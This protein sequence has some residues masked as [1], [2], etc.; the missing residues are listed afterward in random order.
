M[1]S[2]SRK[3]IHGIWKEFFHDPSLWLDLRDNKV[4]ERERQMPVS[5]FVN[6]LDI[7]KW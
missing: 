6:C 5:N 4:R 3:R 7:L 2:T 1:L